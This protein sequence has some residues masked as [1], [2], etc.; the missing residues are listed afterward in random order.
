M[1]E[2]EDYPIIIKKATGEEEPFSVN[3][4]KKSLRNAGADEEIIIEV[5]HDIQNWIFNG[6][7][8]KKI[9]ERA[10]FLL[11]KKETHVAS[12]YKLKKAIMELGPTGYPFEHFMGKIMETQGYSTEVG[13]TVQ[14]FC[15][16]HEVDVVA[17][18]GKEQY[19]VEC[20]YGQSP[21]KTVNVQ[22]PLYIRSRVDD[23]IKKRKELPEYNDFSF[24][25]WVVT[26]TRF[27]TDAIDFGT[28]SG[29]YLLGWDFPAGEGLKDIIDRE[30]IY[31]I[32]VLNNLTTNQKGKLL[33]Q[34]IVICR[35]L[36]ED[37]GKLNPFQLSNRQ[38]NNLM[39]ELKEIL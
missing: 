31:P 5:A 33:E 19:F 18:K 24:F 34:G 15:V 8:T 14:G 6:V 11:R 27:T 16:S 2:N 4:L 29:L 30:R 22:V 10:F 17:T 36:T 32:T 7:T 9:Y 21:G 39:K 3:K 12:R 28:C 23:I 35:Q 37:P 1:N 13:Q 38:Y 25:G 20:K 26:N